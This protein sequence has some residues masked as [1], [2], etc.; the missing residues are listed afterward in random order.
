MVESQEGEAKGNIEIFEFFLADAMKKEYIEHYSNSLGKQMH[1][2]IYGHAGVPLLGFPT[3][4]S[5]CHNYEDFGIIYHL[6]DFIEQGRIQIVT[7]DSVDKESWSCENGIL[8][9]RSARQEQ[10]HNYIIE[11]VYPILM[12]KNTSNML[13]IVTGPS[14]GANHAAITFLRRPEL[15]SGM[16]A[17]S[18]VYN[19]DYFFHGWCDE[20]L[21]KNS[22][23]R[24]LE[25]MPADH[26]YIDLYNQK[27]MIFCVGQGAWEY[28]GAQTLR[29]LKRIFDEKKINAWCDFW[30]SDV[31][32]D[33]YWWFRE[34]RYF[35]P[36]LLEDQ[37]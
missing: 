21:Y 19:S 6:S 3:Q 33:W 17:L 37:G 11:E 10:Y 13:P 12:Q 20:N 15:F 1:L 35:L 31:S 34:L 14:L 25:N 16:L 18:G 23:E 29:N 2:C 36:I 4:D 24:F 30:G 5:N 32:H 7:V 9:W 8:S 28:D 22:P 27:K 26:P